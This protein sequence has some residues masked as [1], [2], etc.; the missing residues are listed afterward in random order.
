MLEKCVK[1]CQREGRL[2]MCRVSCHPPNSAG[3]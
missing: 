2:G 1:P 3:P